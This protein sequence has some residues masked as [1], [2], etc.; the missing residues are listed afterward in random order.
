MGALT[1]LQPFDPS[2]H[3]EIALGDAGYFGNDIYVRRPDGTFELASRGNGAER[4][5]TF[6]L[7]DGS[8]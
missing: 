8:N 6:G 4:L 5:G 2:D 1:T 3:N 7:S